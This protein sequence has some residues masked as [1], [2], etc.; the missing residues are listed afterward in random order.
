[1]LN[2]E[3]SLR[4][5]RELAGLAARSGASTDQQISYAFRRALGRWPTD[6]EQQASRDYLQRQA[7]VLRSER[8]PADQLGLPTHF[9]EQIDAY[10]AAALTEF[11]LALFNASEFL[12]IE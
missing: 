11:C 3:F 7:G 6:E 9:P 8:R 2:S 5:A 1:M 12:Y 10:E 4:T